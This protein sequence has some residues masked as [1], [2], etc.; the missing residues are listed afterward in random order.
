MTHLTIEA[1]KMIIEKALKHTGPGIYKHI[2]QI[3]SDYNVG[4]STLEKWI[5]LYK[6]GKLKL[7][8]TANQ[9]IITAADRMEHLLATAN[10][11]ETKLGAYCRERGLYSFQLATWKKDF[12]EQENNQ[13]KQTDLTTELK[14]L[15]AEN[16]QLKTDLIRKN[17]ALA[18]TTALLVLKKKADLIWGGLGDN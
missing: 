3:A 2:S 8:N 11:D 6:T 1:K 7:H 12:M 18:E 4:L 17:M 9:P 15:R 14:M 16:K 5:R 13:T 10:L